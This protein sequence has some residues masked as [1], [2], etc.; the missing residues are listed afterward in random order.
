[1]VADPELSDERSWTE[2]RRLVIT[3]LER[4]D[5]GMVAL[6][7][8]MDVT[9]TTLSTKIDLT[10]AE[11]DNRITDLKVAVAMLQVKAGMIGAASGFVVSI[12]IMLLRFSLN[13]N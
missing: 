4:I 11:R 12:L 1:M 5:R 13:H 10:I 8:K 2:Y 3:E 6:S 7:A 9:S